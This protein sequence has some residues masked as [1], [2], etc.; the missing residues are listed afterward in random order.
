M[1]GNSSIQISLADFGVGI[2]PGDQEKIF[3]VFYQVKGGFTGKTPGMGLDLPLTRQLVEIHGG[4]IWI[5]PIIDNKNYSFS[6][7]MIAINK[8]D[9]SPYPPPTGGKSPSLSLFF[10]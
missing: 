6:F 9:P 5:M 8:I 4:R 1:I 3:E 10:N 2:S 7:S